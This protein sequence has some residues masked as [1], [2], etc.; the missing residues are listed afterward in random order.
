MVEVD[1]FENAGLPE[2]FLYRP[3][4]LSRQDEAALVQMFAG[5]AFREFEF[6]GFLGK[7]RVVSFGWRY[8]FKMRRLAGD[9]GHPRLSSAG[10]R[11]GGRLRRAAGGEPRPRPSHRISP[12]SCHWLAQ[13]PM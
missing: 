2:G 10:A 4:L 7:R 8:D 9:G 1:L 12:R 5:L 13:G 3:V 11:A 6:Q